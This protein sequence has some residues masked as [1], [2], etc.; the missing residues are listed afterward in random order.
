MAQSSLPPQTLRARLHN[1]AVTV[2]RNTASLLIAQLITTAVTIALF[3]LIA[4]YLGV[5][6]LG[7]Y[8]LAMTGTEIAAVFMDL[9]L[10]YL[11]TREVAR[12]SLQI[13]AYLSGTLVL[14]FLLTG[15]T[16]LG[17]TKALPWF[18]QSPEIRQA[19][20]LGVLSAVFRSFRDLFT[21]FFNGLERMSVT[22]V[23]LTAQAMV[24]LVAGFYVLRTSQDVLPL[25]HVRFVIDVGFAI[26]GLGALLRIRQ[27]SLSRPTIGFLYH[28]IRLSLPFGLF[29]TGAVLYSRMDTV[30]LSVIQDET[31]VGIYEAGRR[32]IIVVEMIPAL[33][34]LALYPTLSRMLARQSSEARW[35]VA[36]S[37]RYMVILG[38][39]IAVGI[40]LIASNLL[41]VVYDTSNGVSVTVLQA[42]ALAIPIRSCAHVF[43]ILLL[44]S[45]NSW[46]RA[47]G[48]WFATATN[49]GLN[50]LLIPRLGPV[51]AAIA[52]VVTSV[53]LTLFYYQHANRTQQF[54]AW[55]SLKPA[56]TASIGMAVVIVLFVGVIPLP[57]L[58]GLAALCYAMLLVKVGGL[59]YSDYLI[60]K[61]LVSRELARVESQETGL[62]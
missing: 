51:G 35:L 26:L 60:F 20:Y 29:V 48:T 59:T 13:W 17:L 38:L 39:P 49:M 44:A 58:I 5:D 50:V 31:A 6:Q 36:Q 21:S 18:Y 9:G 40:V 15:I 14:K 45:G 23:L 27:F 25:L 2:I 22:A 46:A 12:Q 62:S 16:L 28:L 42:L 55:N 7:I 34:S 56:L 8:A 33:F 19:V 47:G 57:T 43:G 37:T 10:S 1:S 4:R 32:L 61:R 30:M 24:W 53:V 54:D 52:S 41:A 11:T 3:A